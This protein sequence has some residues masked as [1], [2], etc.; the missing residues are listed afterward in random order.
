MS[1]PQKTICRHHKLQATV[2][3]CIFNH[4][5][6]D[7]R[8][9]FKLLLQFHSNTRDLLKNKNSQRNDVDDEF[10]V[11]NSSLCKSSLLI[12]LV[13]WLYSCVLHFNSNGTV[14]LLIHSFYNHNPYS[15][16]LII[17][18]FT[19]EIESKVNSR[20]CRKMFASA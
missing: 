20:K 9:I 5:K 15:W 17:R 12:L 14:K 11:H 7:Q 19:R 2:P 8:N 10:S 6:I 1:L 4:I 13:C 18:F 3:M 16:L